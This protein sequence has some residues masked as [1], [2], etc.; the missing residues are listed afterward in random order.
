M[1][2][3]SERGLEGSSFDSASDTGLEELLEYLV[4][5]GLYKLFNNSSN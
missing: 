5:G 3:F 1:S 4:R 2:S